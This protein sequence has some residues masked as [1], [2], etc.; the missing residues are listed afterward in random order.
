MHIPYIPNY[1]HLSFSGCSMQLIAS[2]EDERIYGPVLEYSTLLIPVLAAFNFIVKKEWGIM[3]NF[4]L[5][6]KLQ[7]LT[8]DEQIDYLSFH[9]LN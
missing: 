7:H 2:T 3:Y 4:P 6:H 8:S 1:N 9:S 5:V